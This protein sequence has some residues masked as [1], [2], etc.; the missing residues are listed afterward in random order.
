MNLVWRLCLILASVLAFGGCRKASPPVTPKPPAPSDPAP[1]HLDHAQPKLPTLKLFV[2]NQEIVAETA[3]T[4]PQIATGM[5]FRKEMGTN[6]GML[7]VFGR[8]H[9]VSFYMKNTLI[10][11][12]GAYIDA[13][14]T[15]LEIVDLNPLDETPVPAKSD[16]VVFVLEM[17]QGW[18][19]RNNLS[20]G[21][22]I[23]SEFGSLRDA[24]NRRR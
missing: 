6:E 22:V 17:N 7:F 20:A 2:G 14:G 1:M 23:Q 15:I 10:P 4:T 13:D 9:R 16:Q 5:M 21:A 24:F 3:L 11:L 8:P 12:S 19:K 18:F